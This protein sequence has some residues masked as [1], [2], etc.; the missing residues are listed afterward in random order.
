MTSVNEFGNASRLTFEARLVPL[1]GDR[2]QPTGF[3][4]IGPGR[5]NLPDGT[6]MLLVESSQSII[7][8]LEKQC[9]A[10]SQDVNSE[11]ELVEELQGM[12]YVI[13]RDKG[14]EY[15]TNT[16]MEGHRINSVYI[17]GSR[18]SNRPKI[19]N[20]GAKHE[21]LLDM[22]VEKLNICES[23]STSGEISKTLC[24]LHDLLFDID[25]NSLIHGVFLAESKLLGGRLRIPR[26][27]DGFV[28]AHKVTEAHSGGAKNDI[29]NPSGGSEGAKQGYGNIIYGKT[30]F[31]AGEIIAYFMIDLEQLRSYALKPHKKDFLLTLALWK[32]RRFLRDS[33]RLR[34]SCNLELVDITVTRPESAC[35][36]ELSN[37][38][39]EL[40][41]LI[42]ACEFPES[43]TVVANKPTPNG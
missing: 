23:D 42:R 15:M 10:P 30:D 19:Q 25:P 3:P 12:P 22:F 18:D 35:I 38:V 2:F 37:L 9:L 40:P 39:K 43:L 34:T 32:V 5:Y 16:L 8:W 17:M 11:P 33:I 41:K 21:T 1:Q 26:L 14:G 31:T 13:A 20:N 4:D 28:E 7:N 27:I 24:R 6:S 36:P 29:V